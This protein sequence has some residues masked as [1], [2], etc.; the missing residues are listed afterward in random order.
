M[1]PLHHLAVERN[2]TARGVFRPLE[3]RDDLAGM[4]DF[5]RRRREDHVAGVDLAGMDQGLAVEAEIAA[6]RAFLAKPVDIAEIAV[7]SIE[8]FETVGAGAAGSGSGKYLSSELSL[9]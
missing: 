1:Q 5:L 2:R 3:R 8:N 7:G 4:G 6:L 9:C